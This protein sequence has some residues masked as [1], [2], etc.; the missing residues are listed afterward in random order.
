MHALEAAGGEH[1][2]DRGC[3]YA[4]YGMAEATV[5]I[6]IPDVGTGFT[7]DAVDGEVLEHDLRAVP[8]PP[9]RVGAKHLARCGYPVRGLELRIA[10]PTSGASLED[11]MLGE[12]E[13]RGTSVV[14]GYFRQP[15]A[16][17]VAFREGGWLRT[18]DLGYTAEGDLIVCG[19]LKDIIIV[20][21]RNIFP[22]D[23]ERT[24]N[25]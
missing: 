2:L 7:H 25:S 20:G 3:L 6:S 4:G 24:G 8:V 16:T 5:A 11:R 21:G 12:I 23:G 10:D 17:A 22:E 13:V 18:G 1:G 14:P 19:R 15:E 9:D